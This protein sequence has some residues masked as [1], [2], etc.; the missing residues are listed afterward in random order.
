MATVRDIAIIVLAFESI[1]IGLVLIVL[2]WQVYRL[3]RVLQEEIRPLL[4]DV[5]A[6]VKTVKGTASFMS[7]NVVS[8]AIQASS[9]VA[10]LRRAVKVASSFRRRS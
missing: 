9:T 8:P 10:G 6:T 5:N 1:I 3:I 2:A 7:E 4:E